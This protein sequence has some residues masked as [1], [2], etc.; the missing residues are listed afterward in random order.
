MSFSP[1]GSL[2]L[3]V[4]VAVLAG[5]SAAD[6]RR[7]A[8]VVRTAEDLYSAPD[9]TR[10][11]VSQALLG[12]VVV[13]LESDGSFMRVETPDG[14]RGW[15]SA[16][17]L[18]PSGPVAAYATLGRVAEVTSLMA[19]VYRD[20]DVTTARPKLQAPLGV[21]LESAGAASRAGWQAV[22]LPA[23]DVGYVQ[24]G[25][26]R[27]VDALA[28]V[29][30]GTGADVVA[31]ARRFLGVPY[32]WGGLSPL[33]LDCSGLTSRAWAVHGVTLRRDASLQFAD[34]ALVP[35][36]ES[37]LRAGDLVFF[38]ESRITHVGIWSGEG[39]FVHATTHDR[40]VVQESTLDEPY[41][42]QRYQGARRPR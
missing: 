15:I 34:P 9:V 37:N 39:R 12:Q 42:R 31:T 30:R 22:R 41:W 40:P 14:Y 29:P 17:A 18:R 36:A 8:V 26:V 19:N 20:P 7:T 35:V 3:V 1:R 16:G 27:I 23:G 25:D 6:E 5:V 28:P 32:L 10:D 38:G 11:V 2:G 4:P 33:G 24:D 13:L 21:R